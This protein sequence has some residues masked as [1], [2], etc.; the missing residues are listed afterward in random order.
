ML[1]YFSLITFCLVGGGC[2]PPDQAKQSGTVVSHDEAQ[3][4]VSR[5]HELQNRKG[6]TPKPDP[7]PGGFCVDNCA[8][9][10]QNHTF[11]CAFSIR[12]RACACEALRSFQ[13]CRATCLKQRPP[14]GYQCEQE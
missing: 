1:F 8:V 9:D 10:L 7:D 11:D 6:P 12:P 13:Q 5:L 4:I 2:K 3:Q 14:L